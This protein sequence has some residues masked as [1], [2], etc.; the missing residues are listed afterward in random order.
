[1]RDAGYAILN[2]TRLDSITPS[3]FIQGGRTQANCVSVCE[4]GIRLEVGAKLTFTFPTFLGAM[5][6]IEVGYAYPLVGVDGEG[7]VFVDLGGGF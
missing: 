4:P 2:L 3:M 7:R 5:I 6:G 1:M